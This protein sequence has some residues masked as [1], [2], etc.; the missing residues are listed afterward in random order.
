MDSNTDDRDPE[1]PPEVS[2]DELQEALQWLEELT[3]PAS[4]VPA[5]EETIDS[6][7][8]GLVDDGAGDL[9]DWLREAPK[10]PVE[11]R[12]AD[13]GEFESR[14][15][16]LAK[17]AERES[18]EELPTLE[19]RN[20]NDTAAPPMADDAPQ[21][22]D[23]TLPPHFPSEL[24]PAAMTPPEPLTAEAVLLVP[25]ALP[26]EA[27]LPGDAPVE[28]VATEEPAVLVPDEPDI[29]PTLDGPA[30]PITP[31]A[32]IDTL[33][34]DEELPPIDDLDAAMAWIEELAASQDA[35]I[36]DVPSVADRALAS[37][38]LMEAGLSPDG[39]DRRLPDNELALGD[40]SLLE[41]NTPVNAFV[42][43]E[44][45]ADTIVLVETM[46]ADQGRSL[47]EEYQASATPGAPE[48]SFAEAM[49]FLDD[50]AADQEPLGA[51]T[52]PIEGVGVPLGKT[53]RFVTEALQ[54]TEELPDAW[55]IEDEELAAPWLTEPED[56]AETSVEVSVGVA[57]ED[58]S[59]PEAA[60]AEPDAL[61]LEAA[62]SPPTTDAPE[63]DA[64][65]S[66]A[67]AP[68]LEA[69]VDEAPD[70]WREPEAEG[71][72][73]MAEFVPVAATATVLAAE[74]V[75]ANGNVAATLEE[76]LRALDALALPP[77][78]SLA[79]F[80]ASLP[81][82][83]VRRDLS[84]AVEWLELALGISVPTAPPAPQWSDDELITQMP[85]DP[86][87]VLAWLEQLAEEDTVGSSPQLSSAPESPADA[88]RLPEIDASLD[89][90]TDAADPLIDELSA[91][92]L[93]NMP[94]DPD[95]VMAWLEGLAG[96]RGE[97]VVATSVAPAQPESV[98][99]PA[100][101]ETPPTT[102]SRSRRR[103]GRKS[104]S[105][106]A[107][108]ELAA[109]EELATVEP[110]A[111]A[112]DAAAWEPVDEVTAPD[113]APTPVTAD[114]PPLEVAD[115]STWEAAT[116]VT[117]LDV[118]TAAALPDS[119]VE[120][121]DAPAWEEAAEV[122][123]ADLMVEGEESVAEAL[124]EVVG[125]APTVEDDGDV[126]AIT[127]GEEMLAAPEATV[128]PLVEPD[129]PLPLPAQP[130]RRGRKPK[131]AP[132]TRGA[133]AEFTTTDETTEPASDAAE[134]RP[135]PPTESEQAPPPAKPASWVDL[136][137][138]L[139]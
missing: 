116:E 98:A 57:E 73:D 121:G 27:P 44:D 122:A 96:G 82:A 132:A 95:A 102:G 84:A 101:D 129:M 28:E 78:H 20:L 106:V 14:L 76:T 54:V 77:G 25:E 32:L 120:V 117:A 131:A 86:D 56:A 100:P 55:P 42:A 137:K 94:D 5:T 127:W 4:D 24:L 112:A 130:R 80:N 15:D 109:A 111:E 43:A 105:V 114:A 41:G 72:G 29:E 134:A 125:E 23:D 70:E 71:R 59:E 9:P 37:K 1:V 8:H 48:A 135:Q 40:L 61:E 46:A 38:L 18:I 107:A 104:P 65:L 88:D 36:E 115:E 39:L 26:D 6:P 118:A 62:W 126:P 47:P 33:P 21:S 92:D 11:Q 34:P 133:A 51:Q 10:E 79:E 81:P 2:A 22:T 85:D 113:V 58:E 136:L 31:E 60:I 108:K 19:W 49:A 30:M 7:F 110:T 89:R 64:T 119:L 35:P 138:P 3:G 12:L 139:K 74:G 63:P 128:E 17:M 75:A 90:M 103:R 93:E 53:V 97:A 13:D 52:Q 123:A 91:A 66:V 124:P 50:L 69:S 16:W 45:F 68:W 87:A 99:P 67:D 83:P